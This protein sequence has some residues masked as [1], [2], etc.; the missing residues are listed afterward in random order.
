MHAFHSPVAMAMLA[1]LP[2]ARAEDVPL[3]L[4]EPTPLTRAF[5]SLRAS[6]EA[7]G[8]FARSLA[9]EAAQLGSWAAV[10]AVGVAMARCVPR[11]G[12]GLW[13]RL[14]A[15]FFLAVANSYAGW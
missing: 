9:L 2:T 13:P 5:R 11:P 8:W 14:G 3:G 6:L 4:P 15:V 7:E 12:L 1:R 10:L